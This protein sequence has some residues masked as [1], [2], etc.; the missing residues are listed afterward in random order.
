MGPAALNS[1][2]ALSLLPLLPKDRTLP[3][4]DGPFVQIGSKYANPWDAWLIVPQL[5]AAWGLTV[6]EV[7]AALVAAFKTLSQS[8][9]VT[10]K[11]SAA[12]DS[13]V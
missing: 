5:A 3:E 12:N 11:M 2:K 10:T 6:D 1:N 13:V 7:E 9:G 8:A 4:S